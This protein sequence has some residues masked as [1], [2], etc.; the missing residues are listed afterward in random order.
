[1]LQTVSVLL[2]CSVL[3][4]HF[5]FLFCGIADLLKEKYRYTVITLYDMQQD[6][7]NE[8]SIIIITE[9]TPNLTSLVKT[10]KAT[11]NRKL[12]RGM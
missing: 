8:E 12:T 2:E 10:Q 5:H 4:D 6:S 11:K 1:M 7:D 9:Q 3:L